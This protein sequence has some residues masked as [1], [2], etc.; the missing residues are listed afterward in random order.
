VR[1]HFEHQRREQA[2]APGGVGTEAIGGQRIAA[3]SVQK[4]GAAT[5]DQRG[6]TATGDHGAEHLGDDVRQSRSLGN[7][8]R[9]EAEASRGMMLGSRK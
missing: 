6:F 3:G 5:G 8:R 2:V 7:L 1:N 9:P 4:T